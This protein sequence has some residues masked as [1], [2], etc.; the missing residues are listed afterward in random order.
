MTDMVKAGSVRVNWRTISKPAYEVKQGDVI[1][2]AGKGRLE[3]KEA[4]A[5]VKKDV[6][7]YAVKLIRYT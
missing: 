5:R 3:V 6:T 7:K 4:V 2:V 1:S